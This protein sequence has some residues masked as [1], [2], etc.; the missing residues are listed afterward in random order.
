MTRQLCRETLAA[1]GFTVLDGI[2][3]GAGAVTMA[4][5]QPPDIILLGQQ[6]TDVSA[7]EA[8]TW[9]R[10]NSELRT[11]PVI[12]LGGKPQLAQS[13]S[14]DNAVIPLPRPITASRIRQTLAEALPA[15]G[16]ID[17]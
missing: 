7:S 9:L 5:T 8:V 10:S 14:P 16:T 13:S 11:T 1:A 4:R 2:E 17:L 6:L 15:R 3:S 12:I